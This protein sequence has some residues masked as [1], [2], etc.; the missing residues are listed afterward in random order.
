MVL[1][2]LGGTGGLNLSTYT[3]YYGGA[4][5]NGGEGH[6]RFEAADTDDIVGLSGATLTYKNPSVGQFLPEGGGAPSIGQTVWMNLGVYDPEMEKWQ[7]GNPLHLRA[8]TFGNSITYY[9]QMALEDEANPGNP[10]LED[11]D[12]NDPDGGTLNPDTLSDWVELSDITDLNGYGYSF[13]RIKIIFQL[14]WNQKYTDVLPFVDHL[15][16]PFRY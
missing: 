11:M 15:G 16:I 5:G 2:V 3:Y 6:L 14:K 9:A 13:I 8:E 10:Y 7:P 12:L 1:S 4:G